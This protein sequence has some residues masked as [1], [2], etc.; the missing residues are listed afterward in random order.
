MYP[1]KQEELAV[2][3]YDRQGTVVVHTARNSPV[4]Q[5]QQIDGFRS[6]KSFDEELLNTG[7]HTGK[8]LVTGTWNRWAFCSK[9][10][11]RKSSQSEVHRPQSHGCLFWSS[12]PAKESY[13]SFAA[14][15]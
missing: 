12:I 1:A 10:D 8:L 11:A 4:H 14:V 13:Q 2:V 6:K 9:K 3:L 15:L 5:D 7:T